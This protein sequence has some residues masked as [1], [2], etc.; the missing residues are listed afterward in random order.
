MTRSRGFFNVE[1]ERLTGTGSAPNRITTELPTAPSSGLV[2]LRV[3]ENYT[4]AWPCLLAESDGHAG[5]WQL[6]VLDGYKR[7]RRNITAPEDKLRFV[8]LT[9]GIRSISPDLTV[10]D[11]S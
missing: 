7:E 4:N 8:N 11:L 10:A 5:G 6:S 9:T 3:G 2:Y 1:W